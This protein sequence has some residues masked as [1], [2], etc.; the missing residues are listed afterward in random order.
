MDSRMTT[1]GPR[2]RLPTSLTS[3]YL[4]SEQDTVIGLSIRHTVIIDCV[5]TGLEVKLV[6][7]VRVVSGR[8]RDLVAD[9]YRN[10]NDERGSDLQKPM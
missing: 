3:V 10:A 5:A 2:S 9:R 8:R 1:F 4:F 7:C 6:G